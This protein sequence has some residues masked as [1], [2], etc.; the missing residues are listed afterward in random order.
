MLS[1]LGDT[2]L[3]ELVGRRFAERRNIRP[4]VLGRG[5]CEY[6]ADFEP[7]LYPAMLGWPE[8]LARLAGTISEGL[9]ASS[10]AQFGADLL[11][12]VPVGIDLEPVRFRLAYTRHKMQLDHL[13]GNSKPYAN[14]AAA[15]LGTVIEYCARAIEGNAT[16]TM[17]H[18]AELIA[19]AAIQAARADADPAA[20]TVA[21]FLESAAWSVSES[22]P[23]AAARSAE[24]AIAANGLEIFAAE[25]DILFAV[26]RSL[27]A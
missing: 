17:A 9:P 19:M 12:A 16:P 5:F 24:A 27:E 3:K 20:V 23:R 21:F 15:A 26:L 18:A 11:D 8:W 6:L 2:A 22:A 7:H 10:V 25:R 13:R 4:A 14:Q 1:Y